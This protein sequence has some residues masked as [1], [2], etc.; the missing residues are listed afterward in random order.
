MRYNNL[1]KFLAKI[2]S[3]K[4][5][6]GCVV[7]VTDPTVTEISAEAGFDFCWLDGEHG[8]LDRKTVMLHLMALKGTD[9]A[10][11]FRVA[12]CDHTE[13]KKIIDYAPAGIIIPM[14]MDE[15][16]AE[17]AVAAC[18]YPLAGNR[19][20]GPR[21]GH[22]YGTMPIDEYYEMS[23]REPLVILQIE[24]IEA[25][26]NLDKILAV[27]GVDAIL[28]GP[29]DLTLSMGKAGLW[30]DPEV[31][32]TI[33]T[34]CAK[35]LAAGKLLGAYAECQFDRW[36]KRGVQFLAGINDTGALMRGYKKLIADIGE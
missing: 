12:A 4:L 9:C 28:I 8:E 11:I 32:E 14:I 27:P 25:Y 21:R 30:D 13:I 18:R 26:R 31:G 10:S 22:A 20:C 7:T 34:I 16:D 15:K 36:K 24:H 6:K 5:C 3:G 33:D 23:K 17:Y 1:E 29:Y 2:E 19:G 35:T